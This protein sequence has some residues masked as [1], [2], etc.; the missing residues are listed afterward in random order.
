MESYKCLAIST[1]HI[2]KLDSNR[3]SDLSGT[4]SMI[5]KRE[6]GFFMKLYEGSSLNCKK[7]Y[8]KELNKIIRWAIKNDYRMI[9]IDCDVGKAMP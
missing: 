4:S 5:F 9:E 8:S 6:T 1:A 2:T 3:L 7:Q